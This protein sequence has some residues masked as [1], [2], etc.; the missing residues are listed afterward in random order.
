MWYQGLGVVHTHTPT[1]I[2]VTSANISAPSG[3]LQF[4]LTWLVRNSGKYEKATEDFHGVVV[5]L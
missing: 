3:N 2:S 5:L 4:I 1:S